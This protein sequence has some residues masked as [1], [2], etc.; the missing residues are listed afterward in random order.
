MFLNLQGFLDQQT[1]VW[2]SIPK[3][4][5]YKNDADELIARIATKSDEAGALIGVSGRKNSIREAI[6]L[7]ASSLSGALQAFALEQGDSDLEEQVSVSRSDMLKI[8]E[9]AISGTVKRLTDVA[10]ANQEALLAYGVSSE[11]VTELKTSVEE[12]QGL[13]GKPR[14]ILNN[15]YVAL[16]ALDQLFDECNNLLRD[17]LDNV[18]KLFRES[19]PDFYNGYERART[20]VDM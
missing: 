20:I 6:A 14:M 4:V 17:K 12:F 13:I 10:E 5:G 9:E 2:S 8:K 1:A 18:M 19:N 11:L 3:I 15:K 7:K 16:D